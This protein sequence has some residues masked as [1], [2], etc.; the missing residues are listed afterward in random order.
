MF[1]G[2]GKAPGSYQ[3]PSSLASDGKTRLAVAEREGD[4]FQ[5]LTIR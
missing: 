5:V 1:G 3:Y 4:R 2:L